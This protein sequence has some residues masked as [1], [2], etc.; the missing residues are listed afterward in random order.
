MIKF[1]KNIIGEIKREIK[2]LRKYAE[3]LHSGNVMSV[4][5]NLERLIDKG[6]H[7]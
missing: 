7:E 6:K 1:K 5:I 4:V 3:R 2:I